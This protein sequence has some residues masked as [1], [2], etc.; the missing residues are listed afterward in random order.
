MFKDNPKLKSIFLIG[1]LFSLQSALTAYINSTFLS[2]FTDEKSVGIVYALGAVISIVALFIAPE[3][4][5]R[6]GGHK[7]L[8]LTTGLNILS[9]FLLT[10][11]KSAFYAVP[12]FILYF[13][14]SNVLVFSLDEL[15]KIFSQN[16]STGRV[17]GIYL[18]VVNSAWVIAQVFSGRILGGSPFPSIYLIAFF[19]MVLFFLVSLFGL[20][21]IQDPKY[22][23]TQGLADIKEFFKN[24]NLARIYKINFLLQLFYV[25]MIIYTPIY[26]YSHLGFT[27]KEIGIIFAIM[28]LPFVLFQFPLGKYSDKIGEKKMLI[29]GFIIASFATLSLFFIKAHQVWI[30]ALALFMTRT[31]AAAIE[32]MSDV[33][34]FKHITVLEEKF[35]AT[36]R[37]IAPI[38]Y[39]A[40]PILALIVF[41]IAPAFN[42]IYVVLGALMLYGAYLATGISRSDI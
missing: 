31:G 40:G 26:L 42:F 32:V 14:F 34:F 39:I 10:L 38:A 35:I 29:F 2:S 25:W 4:L 27:W 8:L 28:L 6:M 18:T 15:L 21:N 17:R 1:F 3:I 30:W 5:R 16:A 33:Y 20:K 36:Y 19:I 24:K 37:N 13:T 23:K 7:F 9:I 41:S 22:E 11:A 12:L